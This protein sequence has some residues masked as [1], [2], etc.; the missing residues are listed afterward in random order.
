[1]IKSFRPALVVTSLFSSTGYLSPEQMSSL[2]GAVSF[3]IGYIHLLVS[4]LLPIEFP[5]SQFCLDLNNHFH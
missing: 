5:F 3:T 4:I 2:D 1:M